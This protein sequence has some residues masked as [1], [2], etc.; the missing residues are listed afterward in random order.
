MLCVSSFYSPVTETA[1]EDAAEILR[2]RVV[3]DGLTADLYSE[4]RCYCKDGKLVI[5]TLLCS[6]L[7]ASNGSSLPLVTGRRC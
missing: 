3:G 6:F 4:G 7:T 1:V 2:Q 5:R